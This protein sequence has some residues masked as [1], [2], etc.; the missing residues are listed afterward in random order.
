MVVVVSSV[1]LLDAHA[2]ALVGPA[3]TRLP[4]SPL[5][6]SELAAPTVANLMALAERIQAVLTPISPSPAFVDA[7]RH[8][9]VWNAVPAVEVLPSRARP[10][11]IGATAV[12]SALSLLGLLQFLRGSRPTLKRVS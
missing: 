4:T 6:D 12:G 8:K 5:G 9:L 10:W 7:L 1:D 3:V 2:N 11:I